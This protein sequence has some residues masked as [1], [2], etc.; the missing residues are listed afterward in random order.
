MASFFISYRVESGR[1][2]AG[3][4]YDR[5]AA[6]FGADAIFFDKGSLR[7]GERW[8]DRINGEL[9][10]AAAVFA[11]IDPQWPQSFA[12]R[13][14]E[15]DFVEVELATAIKLEKTI[16]SLLVG[17]MQTMP[18]RGTIPSS[19][20]AMLDRQWV[21]LHDTSVDDYASSVA[22]LIATVGGLDGVVHAVEQ[23]AVALLTRR[24]Y[25][26]AERVLLRQPEEAHG[27]AGFSAWLALARLAGRSFNALHPKERETIEALLRSAHAAEP[28]WEL[29]AILLAILEIDYYE[30][31]GLV[32]AEPIAA[33]AVRAADLDAPS[34]A[35]LAGIRI[36]RRAL[37]ELQ[38][39]SSSGST[40]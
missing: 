39:D 35:L 37:R 4:L 29:P 10:R 2:Y 3:R 24:Q 13:K 21:V 26:E 17:G 23:Q 9:E 25:A 36:S 28:S 33:S 16:I 19:L 38:L 32:S 22:R 11:V 31:H 1:A 6:H 5:L 12:E 30:N 7:G 27:R 8:L 14:A 15:E 18:G 20:H 40:E 34:R